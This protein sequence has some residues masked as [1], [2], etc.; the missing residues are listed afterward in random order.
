MTRQPEPR[1]VKKPRG[2]LT[3]DEPR[4]V[5]GLSVPT[6]ARLAGVS[7]AAMYLAV[8]RGEV[9]SIRLCGRILVLSVPFMRRFG[10]NIEDKALAQAATSLKTTLAH[11]CQTCRYSSR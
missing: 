1:S 10:L 3:L 8:A 4:Q 6:A 2:L 7:V 5:L 11:Q 9:E